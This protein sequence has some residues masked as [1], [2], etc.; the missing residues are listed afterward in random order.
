[1]TWTIEYTE[2]ARIQ[3]RKLDKQMARRLVDYMNER[4]ARLEDPRSLGTALT[5]ASGERFPQNP[6]ISRVFHR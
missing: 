4:I 6:V 5:S 2:T 3:L 1:M